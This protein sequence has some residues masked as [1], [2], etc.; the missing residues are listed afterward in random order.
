MVL[1]SM[2]DLANGR[3]SAAPARDF[4]PKDD[5]HA[6]CTTTKTAPARL[7]GVVFWFINRLTIF[8]NTA[9]IFSKDGGA[10]FT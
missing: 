8:R 3:R 6:G 2:M 1:N 4:Y 7:P 5:T 10:G 9:S